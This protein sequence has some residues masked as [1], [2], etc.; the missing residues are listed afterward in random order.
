MNKGF[1]RPEKPDGPPKTAAPPPPPVGHDLGRGADVLSL[2]G[3][4]RDELGRLG[5]RHNAL[6]RFLGYMKDKLPENTAWD[7]Y[8]AAAMQ[9]LLASITAGDWWDAAD[10]IGSYV[11]RAAK[12]ADR[13]L[14]ERQARE[15]EA[16]EAKKNQ[17][18]T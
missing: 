14:G 15:R 4:V 8:F 16:V 3:E 7:L 12:Y 5:D 13:M 9:G 10:P 6:L 11:I 18:K 1:A 2:L 17:A